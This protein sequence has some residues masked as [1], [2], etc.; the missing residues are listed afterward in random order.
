M[1]SPTTSERLVTM[2]LTDTVF[3]LGIEEIVRTKSCSYM[4]AILEYC[5]T[6]DLEY[7]EIKSLMGANLKDKLR[8][9]AEDEGLMKKTA[10]LP[11]RHGYLLLFLCNN[12][13]LIF[14][15]VSSESFLP[16]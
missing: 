2:F 6:N 3:Q 14:S 9:N 10:R 16:L 15:L 5:D 4:E 7:S 11:L 8:M 12:D 1:L 13:C